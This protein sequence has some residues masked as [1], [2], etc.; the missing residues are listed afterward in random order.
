MAFK[1]AQAPVQPPVQ[2]SVK[3]R[4]AGG[5][6]VRAVQRT[7]S[8]LEALSTS[9]AGASL[10]SLA[11]AAG[12][13]QPTTLRYLSTLVGTGVVEKDLPGGTYRLG[14]GFLL[15]WERAVGDLDPRQVA[16]PYMEALR[17]A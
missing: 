14:L 8:L 10:G 2:A 7:I 1:M 16:G 5:S 12:L 6:D 11:L 9:G 17:D 4:A 15:L 13:S 3:I